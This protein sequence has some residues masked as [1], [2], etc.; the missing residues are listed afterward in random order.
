MFDLGEDQEIGLR[1]EELFR[2]FL[3]LSP[4]PNFDGSTHSLANNKDQET[5]MCQ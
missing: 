4:L 3:M 1:D 5:S 2:L